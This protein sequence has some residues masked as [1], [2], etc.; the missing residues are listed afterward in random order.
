MAKKESLA[1]RKSKDALQS[2][3]A[4]LAKFRK[5]YTNPDAI[6]LGS[7]AVGGALPAVIYG[8][9]PFLPQDVMGVPTEALIGGGLVVASTMQKGNT[10]KVLENLGS[11]M[12]AVSAYK[13]TQQYIA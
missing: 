5:E 2:A 9:A 6:A 7:V 10:K 3:R 8:Y 1:L 11:G 12:L 4:R 13:L